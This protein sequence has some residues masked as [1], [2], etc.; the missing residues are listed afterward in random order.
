VDLDRQIFRHNIRYRPGEPLPERLFLPGTGDPRPEEAEYSGGL[1]CWFRGVDLY[2]RGYF[3]EAHEA[4]EAVW[5]ERSR[6]SDRALF[7]R[8]CIQSAAALLKLRLGVAGGVRKLSARSLDTL[9]LV[10]SSP[11]LGV[12]TALLRKQFSEFWSPLE[13]GC[14]P[15]LTGYPRIELSLEENLSVK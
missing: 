11:L 15:S 13:R 2:N 4:W 3:W 7:V 10:N 14:L 9:G 12:D 6:E 5:M 8:G 1:E